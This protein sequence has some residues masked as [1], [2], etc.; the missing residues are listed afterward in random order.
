MEAV[1]VSGP[2]GR[3]AMKTEYERKIMEDRLDWRLSQVQRCMYCGQEPSFLPLAVHEIERRSHAPDRW[4]V[5]C[6]YLLV[7][8]KCHS[9]PFATMPHAKQLAVKWICDTE[10][11]DLDAWLRLRDPRLQAPKRVTMAEI[12]YY[13]RRLKRTKSE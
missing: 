11:F 4:G 1:P 6:N 13:I 10:H 9:G 12:I 2:K 5:R 7:C 3:Q 8:D